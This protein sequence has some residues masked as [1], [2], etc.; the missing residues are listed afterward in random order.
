MVLQ[1]MNVKGLTISHVKSH[2]Q[3]LRYILILLILV[4]I[5]FF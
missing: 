2:L 1:I 5:L 4:M 3:V